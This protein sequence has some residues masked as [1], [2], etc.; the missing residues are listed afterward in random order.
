M[1][2]I[3]VFSVNY[4]G[5]QGF[6]D[7]FWRALPLTDILLRVFVLVGIGIVMSLISVRLFRKNVVELVW[8]DAI[9]GTQPMPPLPLYMITGTSIS[10]VI[11]I[12]CI[13]VTEKFRN[14]RWLETLVTTGQMAFTHYVGHVVIGMLAIYFV[15][16]ENGL[17]LTFVFWYALVFCLASVFFS[18]LWRKRFNRGPMSM[19][20]RWIAGWNDYNIFLINRLFQCTLNC[21]IFIRRI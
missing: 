13:V 10:F 9:F 15:V 20:M 8:A 19:L 7:I 17:S 5:I 16:G 11:I 21:R 14:D 1:K 4:W 3:A 2:K 12:L 18:Y 6:Y